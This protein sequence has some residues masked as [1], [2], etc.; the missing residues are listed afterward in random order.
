MTTRLSPSEA[1]EAIEALGRDWHGA[2][3]LTRA[4]L[5]EIIRC[6]PPSGFS[7]TLETGCGRST[8]LLSHLSQRHLCFCLPGSTPTDSH[9]L[10]IGSRLLRSES[11]HFVL[12]PTQRT[13]PSYS[14]ESSDYEFV[15]IDGPHAYP[16]PELEYFFLYPHIAPGGV[17]AIDDIHIPTIQNL[18]RFLCDDDMFQRQAVAGNTAFFRRTSAPA[19]PQD[20]DGWETQNY[21]RRRFPIFHRGNWRHYPGYLAERFLPTSMTRWLRQHFRQT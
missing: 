19:F 17:L 18:Y 11:V 16:C 20:A 10:V 3:T 5:I 14:L 9:T 15:L 4:A 21:N 7:S 1:L 8:L 2:G 13:L 12:G 6:C